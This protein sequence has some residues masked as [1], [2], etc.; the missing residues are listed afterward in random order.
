[1]TKWYAVYNSNG[2]PDDKI[3]TV[4]K[5]TECGWE[6]DCGQPGYGITRAD[7]EFLAAAANEKDA[8]RDAMRRLMGNFSPATPK[9]AARKQRE[10]QARSMVDGR[11]L[12]AKGRTAQVNIQVR[13]EVKERLAVFAE[14]EGVLIADWFEQVIEELPVRGC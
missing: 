7:A 12:R 8:V 3:W 13:P 11:K 5:N 9:K 14:A 1:M 2:D 6:T 10:K 4:S